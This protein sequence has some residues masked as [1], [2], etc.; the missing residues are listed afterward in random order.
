M[1]K[2]L[3]PD[4]LWEDPLR[5]PRRHS[6]GLLAAWLRPQLPGFPQLIHLEPS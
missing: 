5:A 2:E 1:A 3:L 6:C 4:A